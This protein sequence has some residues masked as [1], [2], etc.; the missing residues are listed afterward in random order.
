MP[1]V[2][3]IT[4]DVPTP[5]TVTG[6]A[7]AVDQPTIAVIPN[8]LATYV[9]PSPSPKAT[10]TLVP[11]NPYLGMVAGQVKSTNG[12]R[13]VINAEPTGTVRS[14]Q[15]DQSV[16]HRQSTAPTSSTF[17]RCPA[18]PPTISMLHANDRDFGLVS[19]LLVVPNAVP[20][21]TNFTLNRRIAGR[22]V[23]GSLI[24][25]CTGDIPP[26][27]QNATLKIL[28]AVVSPTATPGKH[29]PTPTPTNTPDCGA[30][31]ATDCV[32]VAS[33][34][35]DPGGSFPTP[36]PGDCLRRTRLFHRFRRAMTTC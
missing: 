7:V 14:D 30:I 35:T 3:N 21:P 19:N 36:V 1:L 4:L 18:A 2:I 34:V 22:Q 15:P 32:V 16:Q 6:G 20:S 12:T 28:E 31:P 13:G 27:L 9:P 17:P 24:D 26:A 29:S 23:K 5:L 10:P 11:I 33:G 8:S 25:A